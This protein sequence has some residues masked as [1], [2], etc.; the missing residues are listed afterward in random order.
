MRKVVNIS[1]F[2]HRL[3]SFEAIALK[4]YLNLTSTSHLIL[5]SDSYF[6][7]FSFIIYRKKIRLPSK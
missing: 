7:D 4:T 3:S 1:D 5:Q 2:S 6:S